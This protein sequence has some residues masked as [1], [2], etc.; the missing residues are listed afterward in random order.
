MDMSTPD[1]LGY[2]LHPGRQALVLGQRNAEWCGHGPILKKT[3]RLANMSP[4][5]I[6]QARLFHQHAPSASMHGPA[7]PAAHAHL[8]CRAA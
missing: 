6:G 1:R 2:L 3:W 8:T 7:L 5:L 4:D